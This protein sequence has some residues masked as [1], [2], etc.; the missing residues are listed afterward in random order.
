MSLNAG[1][2]NYKDIMERVRRKYNFSELY[3]DD[4]KEWIWD[5]IGYAGTLEMLEPVSANVT[6]TDWKGTLPIDIYDVTSLMVVDTIAN[7]TLTETGDMFFS[8]VGLFL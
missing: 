6:I 7:K 2:T 5:V 3:D 1:W 4:V 8:T